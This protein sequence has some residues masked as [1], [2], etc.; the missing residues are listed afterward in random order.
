MHRNVRSM[1]LHVEIIMTVSDK[2]DL[3]F[4]QMSTY[5]QRIAMMHRLD[6][7]KTAIYTYRA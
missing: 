2:Q 7:R 4:R 3:A 1:R 6:G 5:V